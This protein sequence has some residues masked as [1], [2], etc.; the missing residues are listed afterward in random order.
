[1]TH[2][3]DVYIGQP[4]RPGEND[5]AELAARVQREVFKRDIGLPTERACGLRGLTAQIA[6]LQGDYATPVDQAV[7]GDAVLM[8]SR[9][10][11]A[12][13]GV[14]CLINGEA[15]V[16]HAMKNAG[17][18]CRHRVRELANMGLVVEGFYRWT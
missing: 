11:L 4:Y 13:I 2:W 6:D 17:Q 8:R 10:R 5:C 7:E 16:L 1:M 18:V 12:H 15:W 14:F 3:S 9:G